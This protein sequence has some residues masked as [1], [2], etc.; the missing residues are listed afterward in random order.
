[1]V[2]AFNFAFSFT[3]LGGTSD[4]L[5][6]LGEVAG[7]QNSTWRRRRRLHGFLRVAAWF[8][9]RH[10]DLQQ[11]ACSNCFPSCIRP[12]LLPKALN[13]AG[14]LRERLPRCLNLWEVQG[15]L[16]TKP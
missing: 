8:A 10:K 16:T 15:A 14:H 5:R 4:G 11:A 3:A 1:M 9:L 7:L 13:T 2:V 12:T 6:V